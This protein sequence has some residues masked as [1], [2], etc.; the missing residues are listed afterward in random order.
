[1]NSQRIIFLTIFTTLL[2]FNSTTVTYANDVRLCADVY[3]WY[4]DGPSRKVR[5]YSKDRLKNS[6]KVFV[7]PTYWNNTKYR[8]ALLDAAKEWNRHLSRSY[9]HIEMVSYSEHPLRNWYEKF[10]E[11]NGYAEIFPSW[12]LAYEK[13]SFATDWQP[14]VEY[15]VVDFEDGP[16]SSQTGNCTIEEFDVLLNGRVDW[17]Q[18]DN[19][20]KMWR[21]D[22]S[23]NPIYE[24]TNIKSVVMHELGHVSLR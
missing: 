3:K 18:S 15:G 4:Q 13:G 2:Y 22:E 6:E 24:K 9:N 10:K 1:M 20:L 21:V 5:K 16:T 7:H 17:D 12:N 19:H 14:Y 23:F 8:E 11:N